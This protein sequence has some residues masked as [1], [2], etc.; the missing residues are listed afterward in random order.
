[1]KHFFV[2]TSIIFLSLIPLLAL[3]QIQVSFP[4]TRAV[5]Q[6]NNAN[7]ATFRITGYYTATVTRI[8]A[9][10]VARDGQGTTTDWRTIQGN[11]AGGTFVGDLLATGGYGPLSTYVLNPLRAEF[12]GPHLIHTPFL[13]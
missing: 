13:V 1:M 9:R 6:R 11:P 10:V 7:Q 2:T 8:E 3:S 12:E 5:F 4:T